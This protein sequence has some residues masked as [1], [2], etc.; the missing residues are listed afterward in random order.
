MKCPC[1]DC[2]TLAICKNISIHDIGRLVKAK[3]K[4]SLL[5]DYLTTK[6]VGKYFRKIRIAIVEKKWRN[7]L[8][9]VSKYLF[10][11]EW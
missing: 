9:I 2:I 10:E 3:H 5:S 1:E 8:H 7:R 11:K 6:K 4:C